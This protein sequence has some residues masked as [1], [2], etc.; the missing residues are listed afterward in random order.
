MSER[1]RTRVVGFH[2]G[3]NF[4]L[5]AELLEKEILRQKDAGVEVRAFLYCNPN[6]PLGVVYPRQLTLQLMGVCKKY[7][8][9]LIF[10]TWCQTSGQ[11]HF[12]SDEIYALSVFDSTAHF[13]S[14]L[15]FS[16]EEVGSIMV[17]RGTYF[18]S[19]SC[20]T[21]PG[22][23]SFGVSARTLDW[24]ASGWALYTRITRT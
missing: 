13:S 20:R 6:N 1:T 4:S 14:V 7:Q 24:P 3:P 10:H 5:T 9:R 18:L 2:L 16:T 19:V 8:V 17:C 23:T 12:I 21:P 11:I 22:P 15:S